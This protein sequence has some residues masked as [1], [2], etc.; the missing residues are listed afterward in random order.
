M[1][2]ITFEQLKLSNEM[3]MAIADL[4]YEEATPIQAQAI[5]LLLEGRDV[6]GQ[7]QTGTGKTAAF[8]IPAIERLDP[9]SKKPQV[10]VLCPTRELAIQVAGEIS[11]LLKYF[12]GVYELPIYGG[13]PID[14]QIRGLRRG[15]QIIIGTPGRML[16]HLNRRT[17][18]LDDIK[19]V[20]L[21]EADEMLN[22]GFR[23]DI[24]K[25]LNRISRDRQ[26]VMFSATM[27]EAVLKL[28]R[29]YQQAPETVRVVH[30]KLTVPS[31]TQEY[32]EVTGQQRMELL[33][34]LIDHYNPSLAIVFCNTKRRVDNV[35][36]KLA[37]R[38]YLAVGIHG[39]LTQRQRDS[40]M[41]KFRSG[42]ADI[43][44]ATDV[45]AR[46][47]DVGN[48]EVVFNFDMPND[49]EYYVHR[50]GRTG[51]AGKGGRACS[52]VMHRDLEVLMGIEAYTK[53][54]I[55]R[56]SLPS[57]A[58][59]KPKTDQTIDKIV[60]TLKKGELATHTQ[61]IEGLLDL[62]YK[63]V[64]V[65]AALLSI[66]EARPKPSPKPSVR[67]ADPSA[68]SKTYSRPKTDRPRGERSKT[69]RNEP[70]GRKPFKKKKY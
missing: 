6:I 32:F 58:D 49:E 68:Q 26:T 62:G 23:P 39:G 16:D 17:I 21:D 13:Q 48:V 55:N 36:E 60:E 33:G 1:K 14:R 31:I 34:R 4:G 42:T 54:K 15:A 66:A 12:K 46:G 69:S 29:T 10:L 38:G 8:G 5:P 64:D 28:A 41:K 11:K 67:S 70:S 59:D 50:I 53:T 57:V 7:A 22:M 63:S 56:G 19:T 47:I 20:I 44:V 40:V 37:S 52:F 45:A 18:S 61:R 9:K 3:L 51:R 25:I 43:L 30:E 27:S 35:A 2:T 24:E 65:A